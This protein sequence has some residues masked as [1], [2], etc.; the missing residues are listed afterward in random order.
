[1]RAAVRLVAMPDAPEDLRAPVAMA[2]LE[3]YGDSVDEDEL[4]RLVI[5]M[6]EVEA[7]ELGL[8]PATAG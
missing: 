6:C 5:A 1:M 8:H 7:G 2:L 3:R 4:V